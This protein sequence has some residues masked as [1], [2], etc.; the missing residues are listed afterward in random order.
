MGR[1]AA[2][3][4]TKFRLTTSKPHGNA[5]ATLHA[6]RYRYLYRYPRPPWISRVLHGRGPL[7]EA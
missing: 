5:A 4:R 7:L 3:V 1:T 6:D 2:N